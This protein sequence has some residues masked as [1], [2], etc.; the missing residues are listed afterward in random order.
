VQTIGADSVK[1][2]GEQVPIRAEAK[3]CSKTPRQLI[4]AGHRQQ[5]GCQSSAAG[6]ATPSPG[7]LYP[8]LHAMER[9]GYL[10]SRKKR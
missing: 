5:E 2:H 4:I 10:K 1:I 3:R 9:S 6:R 7:I 8:M